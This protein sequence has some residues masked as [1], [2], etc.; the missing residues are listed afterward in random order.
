MFH[1]AFVNWCQNEFN[2]V[3][4]C[5]YI[6]STVVLLDTRH[7][8]HCKSLI[9][10]LYL[11]LVNLKALKLIIFTVYCDV[12]ALVHIQTWVI[13]KLGSQGI[14]YVLFYHSKITRRLFIVQEV[15][16]KT[17]KP[18]Y[19]VGKGKKKSVVHRKCIKMSFQIP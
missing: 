10:F 13:F 9:V 8:I 2:K 3:I 17:Q 14:T 6:K 18:L 15:H 5:C 7:E 1:N 4:G 19:K 16:F 12:I 11:R